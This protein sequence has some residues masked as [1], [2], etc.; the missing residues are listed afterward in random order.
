MFKTLYQSASKPIQKCLT[1]RECSV[2]S[3]SSNQ[4]Q[5]QPQ[6]QYTTPTLNPKFPLFKHFFN[7]LHRQRIFNSIPTPPRYVPVLHFSSHFFCFLSFKK[8]K[9]KKT[10]L[11]HF[12]F[13]L[14]SRNPRFAARFGLFGCRE[15]VG[16]KQFYVFSLLVCFLL[17]L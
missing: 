17:C 9:N 11:F 1:R 4:S 6:P 5:P 16:K 13:T 12:Y 10:K 15:Y 3:T 7:Y 2:L 14:H 8:Q